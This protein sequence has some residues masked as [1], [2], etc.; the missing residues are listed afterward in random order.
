MIVF[1]WQ[2]CN[3]EHTASHINIV[4]SKEHTLLGDDTFE[5]SI[6]NTYNLPELH[7]VNT[8]PIMEKWI[9]GG[10]KWGTLKQ[11]DADNAADSGGTASRV[12]QRHLD[13]KT[14]TFLF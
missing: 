10:R 12:I 13:V 1:I 6:F 14:Q 9:A 8:E 11:A 5:A 2:S 4:K 3:G 7:E